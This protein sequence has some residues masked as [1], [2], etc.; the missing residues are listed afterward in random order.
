LGK[1]TYNQC[2]FIFLFLFYY[3]TIFTKRNKMSH[4]SKSVEWWPKLV[5]EKC[6]HY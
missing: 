5:I 3:V 2:D 6:C 4:Y 1:W